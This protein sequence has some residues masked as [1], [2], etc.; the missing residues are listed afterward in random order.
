MVEPANLCQPKKDQYSA[1]GHHQ[2]A[3]PKN[4][5]AITSCAADGGAALYQR[6]TLRFVALRESDQVGS[7]GRQ[8]GNNAAQECK[9]NSHGLKSRW[10]NISFRLD[11][12]SLLVFDQPRVKNRS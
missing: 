4:S 2:A 1:Q 6:N 3:K 10:V 8:N 5:L 7:G 12:S 9:A 11:L